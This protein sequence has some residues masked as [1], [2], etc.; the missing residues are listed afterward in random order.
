MWMWDDCVAWRLVGGIIR[1]EG[2]GHGHGLVIDT[3]LYMD[4]DAATQKRRCSGCI[5]ARCG[6]AID[7]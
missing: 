1:Q 7:F 6:I 3:R 2:H 5:R 4:I